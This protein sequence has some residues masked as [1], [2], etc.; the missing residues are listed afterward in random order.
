V[1]R[2]LSPA[3]SLTQPHRYTSAVFKGIVLH[4]RTSELFARWCELAAFT[5]VYRSHEGVQP[6][7]NVQV[8]T[9]TNSM[10]A[11]RKFALV[12]AAL[13]T[14]RRR[15]LE[16]AYAKGTPV[17]RHMMMH[18]P[19]DAMA[20]VITS[21]FMFGPELLV[22]PVV[23]APPTSP[24]LPSPSRAAGALSSLQKSPLQGN[25][26]K[27]PPHLGNLTSHAFAIARIDRCIVVSRLCRCTFRWARGCD[28]GWA[29]TSKTRSTT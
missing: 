16:E 29:R 19:H 8:D 23:S 25:Y 27:D 11:F 4:Q 12:H 28:Y 21:Q 2:K 15:L 6:S 18:Y 13:A 1:E 26:C 20:S 17:M 3:L 9:D 22:A 14:Y 10:A 7:V 24:P 5:P